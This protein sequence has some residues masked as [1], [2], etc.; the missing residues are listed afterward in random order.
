MT[1]QQEIKVTIVDETDLSLGELCGLLRVQVETIVEMVDESIVTPVAATEGRWRF[2]GSDLARLRRAVR[3]QQDLGLNLPGVA[4]ALD[5]MDEVAA[6][7]AQ[8]TLS[9]RRLDAD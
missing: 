8:L 1:R 4:V 7:R 5:L 3:L 2:R 6:L 9:M